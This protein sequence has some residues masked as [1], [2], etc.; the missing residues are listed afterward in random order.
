[1]ATSEAGRNPYTAS[2]ALGSKYPTSQTNAALI[3]A[4][5]G[6]GPAQPDGRVEPDQ[7]HTEGE[8]DGGEE[9]HRAGTERGQPALRQRRVES[10]PDHRH[11]G[12]GTQVDDQ[13]CL[14]PGPR[15]RFAW[16]DIGGSSLGGQAK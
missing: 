5:V 1:M 4:V 7:D 2:A 16:M 10:D 8:G 15:T 11:H 6:P 3:A 14:Q 13:P 12:E 9:R